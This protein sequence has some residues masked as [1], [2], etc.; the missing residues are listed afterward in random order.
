MDE[1]T[2]L[3]R[4]VNFPTILLKICMERLGYFLVVI[5]LM[6]PMVAELLWLKSLIFVLLFAVTLS[7]FV[8]KRKI[9][10]HW[11]VF[12]ITLTI[13]CFSLFFVFIG[14][15]NDSP[16]WSKQLKIYVLW[17]IIYFF[18]I[19]TLNSM[20]RIAFIQRLLIYSTIGVGV[21][22]TGFMLT[23]LGFIPDIKVFS[24]F[25]SE[26]LAITFE[27]G[28][29][30]TKFPG[31]NSLS[32]LIPY[33]IAFLIINF[34]NTDLKGVVSV[35]WVLCAILF[36]VV[37]L[38]ISGRRAILLVVA[39]TPFLLF[40]F[41]K[42]QPIQ[43]QVVTKKNML[44]FLVLIFALIPGFFLIFNFYYD[45]NVSAFIDM[46]LSGFD[47]ESSD[48][49][50]SQSRNTQF[51]ALIEGWLES[52]IFGSGLGSSVSYIRSEEMPW[53][54]ELYYV[55]LLFQTGL[56]GLIVYSGGI[57]WIYYKGISVIRKGNAL[58]RLMLPTLIGMSG[59]LIAS[60]SNPY[61]PRFDGLWVIFI[62]VAMINYTL[63]KKGL[64]N[65]HE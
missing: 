11:K 34:R 54:Y 16:G 35:W 58:G 46:F 8:F 55:A 59:T 52:P 44:K 30:E 45:F 53:S 40:F 14:W 65:Q 64:T 32:F 12:N 41:K 15:I 24:L 56:L 18:M 43:Q 61:L 63:L 27:S 4:L 22:G 6:F 60:F 28:Y 19:S 36:S 13:L 47:F 9:F 57:F 48:A 62:P 26:E 25:E 23:N 17:P 49:N 37:L 10:I 7:G 20:K 38:F 21:Y 50:S 29:I 3:R 51:F 1:D 42:F 31:L 39:L 33:C 5:M 2:V